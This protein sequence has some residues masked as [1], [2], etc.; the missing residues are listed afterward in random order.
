MVV[1]MVVAAFVVLVA[2]EDVVELDMVKTHMNLPAGR[3][4]RGRNSFIPCIPMETP[5]LAKK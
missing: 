5:L 2:E 1:A 3:E 4:I